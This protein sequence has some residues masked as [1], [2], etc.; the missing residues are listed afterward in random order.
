MV[1]HG[2]GSG[3]RYVVSKSSSSNTK[4]VNG[5]TKTVKVTKLVYSDGT[6]E[7]QR[8]ETES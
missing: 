7:E 6:T 1:S 2:G 8:E 3:G 5:H 4:T